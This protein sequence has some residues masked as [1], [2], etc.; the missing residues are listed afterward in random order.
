MKVL[1][2]TDKE[3]ITE[4]D[5]ERDTVYYTGTHDNDTLLGWYKKNS[6]LKRLVTPE[7]CF[8][9]IE[10]LF[11]SKTKWV[12]I[13]LQDIL[14]LDSEARL[15]TPGTREGNWTW[16]YVEEDLAGLDKGKLASIIDKY[17]R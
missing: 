9:F 14:G 6:G 15:N 11:L 4:N 7:M 13:P 16:R 17:K 5:K 2:F 8:S 10:T 3:A 1:Q 12:I